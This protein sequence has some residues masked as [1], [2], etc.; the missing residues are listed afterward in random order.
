LYPSLFC[1]LL[2]PAQA[3]LIAHYDFADGNLLDDE[4]GTY[5]LTEVTN[6]TANVSLDSGGYATFPGNDTTN[7]AHLQVTGPGGAGTFTVSL[8]VRTDDWTQGSFQGIFSNNSGGS[9]A[10]F[11][12]QL[13]SSGG[14]IRV[15]SSSGVSS[16][17]YATSNLSSDTWYNFIVR[18]TGAGT[19]LWIT[20]QGAGTAVKVAEDVDTA[21]GGLQ[22]F[23][24]GANRGDDSFFR[25]DMANVKIYD[26]ASVSLNTLLAEGPQLVPEP[27][28][29]AL[30]GLGGLAL[31]LRRRK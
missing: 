8:W 11:S 9:G 20:E 1:A 23:R 30:L 22:N 7:E 14:N 10:S 3:A 26:D 5:T 18:K 4:Q 6:G 29:A 25:M 21:P 15:R 16:I 13:D 12:W 28:S 24:L 27:S 17:D 2:V 19:E 31:I